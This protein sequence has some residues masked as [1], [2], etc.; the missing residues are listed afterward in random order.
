MK[1]FWAK[2]NKTETCWLWTASTGSNGYGQIMIEKRPRRTHRVSWELTYGPIDDN[3]SVLHKCDDRLCVNPEHLFLGSQAQN[4]ADMVQ[5]RRHYTPK[6][7]E[8]KVLEIRRLFATGNCDRAT[9]AST[10]DV[11]KKT[12]NNV[13]HR[14][15]WKHI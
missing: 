6:L 9:L 11:D 7:D 14:K 2:V 10:F 12:I 5:K 15:Q 4:I 3:I 13:I 1:R 8:S